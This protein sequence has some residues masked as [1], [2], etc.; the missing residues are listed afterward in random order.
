MALI[1]T[2]S[3]ENIICR[4]ETTLKKWKD[5]VSGL[6]SPA[7]QF[8]LKYRVYGMEETHNILLQLCFSS[9][10]VSVRA[11]RRR[12]IAKRWTCVLFLQF[13]LL[14]VKINKNQQTEKE[15]V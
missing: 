4:K 14:F 6:L 7:I 1:Q 3:Y 15:S 9:I 8:F 2:A 12:E 13:L 5:N 11:D 10:A